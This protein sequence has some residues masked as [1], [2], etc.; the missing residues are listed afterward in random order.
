MQGFGTALM[1]NTQ[2]L[3]YFVD[4]Q[5]GSAAVIQGIGVLSNYAVLGQ[6]G[7]SC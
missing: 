1:A 6:V 5:E 4:K 2:L 7:T 3:G